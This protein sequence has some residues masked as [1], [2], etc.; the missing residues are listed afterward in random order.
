MQLPPDSTGALRSLLLSREG[1]RERRNEKGK[2]K[3]KITN[4]KTGERINVIRDVCTSHPQW[5]HDQCGTSSET[6]LQHYIDQLSPPMWYRGSKHLGPDAAGI[7][8][9]Q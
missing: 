4:L 6:E 8:I 2:M 7:E 1:G 9:F 3:M 5:V